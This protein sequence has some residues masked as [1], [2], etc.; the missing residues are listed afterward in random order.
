[1]ALPLIRVAALC[2]TAGVTYW[3]LHRMARS[4]A[5]SCVVTRRGAPER[6]ARQD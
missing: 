1:M 4:Q 3:R 5:T 6:D 2:V